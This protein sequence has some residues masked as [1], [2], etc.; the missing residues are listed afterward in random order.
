M[1][2]CEQMHLMLSAFEDAEL[3][4]HEMQEVA[5]H[6]ARCDACTSE[7]ASYATIARELRSIAPQPSLEGF[8]KS[9]VA[10][11]DAL[12]VPLSARIQ[13][14]VDRVG[15][16]LQSGFAAGAAVAAVAI[17]TAILVTPY[18]RLA[19]ERVSPRHQLASLKRDSGQLSAPVT[20]AKSDIA[21]VEREVASAAAREGS[22]AEISHLET[23]IPSVAMWSEPENDTTV[24][25]LPDQQQ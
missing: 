13:R 25:W 24:I 1:P 16:Q 10:R 17:L 7:L 11:I 20:A 19:L 9:V 21:S 8:A 3:E 22:E 12:P 5:R 2:E 18:A 6:L 14:W 15:G 23:D 4:P